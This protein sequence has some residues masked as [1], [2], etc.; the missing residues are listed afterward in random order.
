M[1]T[2]ITGTGAV[3][4]QAAS[5]DGDGARIRQNR[6]LNPINL[7]AING[8]ANP[9]VVIGELPDGSDEIALRYPIGGSPL[10]SLEAITE[11]ETTLLCRVYAD[12]RLILEFTP[13]DQVMF[14][15]PSGFKAHRY[16]F[17]LIGNSNVFSL[18][19][20]ETAREL[21]DV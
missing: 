9:P 6:G 8:V 18:A 17:E 7:T 14:R 12:G 11:Y 3:A 15:L 10:Y 21:M 20:A 16:Q 4:A 2:T 19:A 1:P 5:V 13:I